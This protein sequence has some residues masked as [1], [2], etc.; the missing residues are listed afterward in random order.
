MNK[1]PDRQPIGAHVVIKWKSDGGLESCYMSFA[2][3]VFG[4][5]D[6]YGVHDDYIFYYTSLEELQ[7]DSDDSDWDVLEISLVYNK[8]E[9]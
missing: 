7:A 3:E 9:V 4:G 5:E 8:D 6:I 2:P 1:S